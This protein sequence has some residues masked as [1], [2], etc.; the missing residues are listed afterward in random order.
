MAPTRNGKY[1]M[2]DVYVLHESKFIF[3][4]SDGN[5]LVSYRKL[6]SKYSS[7]QK[8][9]SNVLVLESKSELD[10]DKEH[11]LFHKRNA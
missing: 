10:M 6:L 3:L 1:E 9:M 2:G 4:F 8:L 7:S 5:R 11:L